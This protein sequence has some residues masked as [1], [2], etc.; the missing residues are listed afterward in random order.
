MGVRTVVGFGAGL[1]GAVV[2]VVVWEVEAVATGAGAV[3]PR[4][5]GSCRVIKS[6]LHNMQTMKLFPIAF[7][8]GS[9]V[10]GKRNFRH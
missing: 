8:D 9:Y 2:V 3:A 10:L 1:E 4:L 7:D 5:C 6:S